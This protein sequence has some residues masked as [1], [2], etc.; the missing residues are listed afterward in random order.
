MSE[1]PERESMKFDV[2][3]R[4]CGSGRSVSGHPG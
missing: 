3:I 2:V 1:L 4:P